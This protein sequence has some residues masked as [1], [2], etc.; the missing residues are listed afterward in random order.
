MVTLALVV[1]DVYNEVAFKVSVMDIRDDFF[2]A[3]LTAKSLD[4]LTE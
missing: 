4:P 3:L 1:I 2:S